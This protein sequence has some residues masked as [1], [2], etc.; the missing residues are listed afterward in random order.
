MDLVAAGKS[1]GSINSNLEIRK[2]VYFAFFSAFSL[3]YTV[4]STVNY[5]DMLGFKE[6][7]FLQFSFDLLA[8]ALE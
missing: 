8:D 1:D 7:E 3:L 4:S 5:W 6:N 2:A